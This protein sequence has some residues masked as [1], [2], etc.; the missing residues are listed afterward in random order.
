[1]KRARWSRPE[2]ARQLGMSLEDV[3]KVIGPANAIP[4]KE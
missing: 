3:E 4:E 1:M 2:I